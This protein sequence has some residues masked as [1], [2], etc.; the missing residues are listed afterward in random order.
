MVLGELKMNFV[1]L[2]ERL[3]VNV[4]GQEGEYGG[5]DVVF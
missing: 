3:Y 2:K 1:F 5:V 4:N